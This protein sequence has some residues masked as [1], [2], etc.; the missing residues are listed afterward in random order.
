ME[1]AQRKYAAAVQRIQ[2]DDDDDHKIDGGGNH[3]DFDDGIADDGENDHDHA[4]GADSTPTTD[5][6]GKLVQ[7]LSSLSGIDTPLVRSINSLLEAEL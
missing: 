5:L 6:H 2:D 1:L 7:Y 3:W 4:A